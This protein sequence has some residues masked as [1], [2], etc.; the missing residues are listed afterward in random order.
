MQALRQEVLEHGIKITNIQPGDVAT[1]L[2]SRSTDE[3]VRNIFADP[4]YPFII[5]QYLA[6]LINP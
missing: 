5:P 6:V 1:K 3:E 2:A 4:P